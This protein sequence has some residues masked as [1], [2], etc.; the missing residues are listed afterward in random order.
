MARRRHRQPAARALSGS[1]VLNRSAQI[2]LAGFRAFFPQ[3]F[4]PTMLF[5]LANVVSPPYLK[6]EFYVREKHR[7][8]WPG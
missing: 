4:H 2:A 7:E 8:K 6:T 3:S 1:A 5:C